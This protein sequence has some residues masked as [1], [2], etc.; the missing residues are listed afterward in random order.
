[1]G[2]ALARGDWP[3]F[4]AALSLYLVVALLLDTVFF[5]WML[6][7]LEGVG[8]FGELLR[9]RAASDLL[10]MINL[11]AGFGGLAV[12]LRRRYGLS[13]KSATGAVLV[14]MLHDLAAMGALAL[15][16]TL[17]VQGVPVRAAEPL[18]AVRVFALGS[19][20][21]YGLCVAAS[22]SYRWVPQRYQFGSVLEVFTRIKPQWFLAFWGLR[23]LKLGATGLFAA[24]GLACFGLKVPLLTAVGFTQVVQLVRSLPVS[25][26]G[27][28]IDQMTIPALFGPWDPVDAP[29]QVM[30]FAI[31]YTF[32]LLL[33]RGLIGLPFLPRAVREAREG[34]ERSG[35]A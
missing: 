24:A 31:V 10:M 18:E 30:A 28:G 8:S 34:A 26:F 17:V 27:I 7:T 6:R 15:I 25:A 20:G 19:L 23:C 13:W 21:F 32:S 11:V 3:A 29:G 22:L 1:V 9:T 35:Q 5:T 33:G 4:V 2:K 12:Y 16:G 14:E